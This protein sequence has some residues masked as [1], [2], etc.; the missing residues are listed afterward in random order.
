MTP[1][2]QI[3]GQMPY[4]ESKQYF[5]PLAYLLMAWVTMGTKAEH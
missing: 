5:F 4:Q 2:L 3:V 1:A